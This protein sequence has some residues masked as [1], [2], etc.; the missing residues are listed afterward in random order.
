[1]NKSSNAPA[2]HPTDEEK[3]KPGWGVPV[4]VLG[5]VALLLRVV[6]VWS[7][8]A[9]L[10]APLFL[11]ALVLMAFEWRLLAR[12]RRRMGGLDWVLMVVAHLGCAAS[13]AVV[14]GAS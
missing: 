1:M 11:L 4:V 2:P 8:W 12:S 14:L 10:W 13:L 7:W 9:L 3:Q 5:V 6:D